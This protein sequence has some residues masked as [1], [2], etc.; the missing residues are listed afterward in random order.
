MAVRCRIW[1][2]IESIIPFMTYTLPNACDAGITV[3]YCKYKISSAPIAV[4]SLAPEYK[5]LVDVTAHNR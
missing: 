5:L 4:G 2:T 3:V 1:G